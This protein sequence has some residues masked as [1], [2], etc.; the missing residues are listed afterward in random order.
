MRKS[1]SGS[2][3]VLK[4]V[5]YHEAGHAVAYWYFFNGPRFK[6]VTIK[7]EE[8]AWGRIVGRLSR[9]NPDEDSGVRF[10]VRS[11]DRIIRSLAGP[12]AERRLRGK[13]DHRGASG[14]WSAVADLV[15]N[16]TGSERQATALMRYFDIVTEEFIEFRWHDIEVVAAALLERTTLTYK[17]VQQILF[18]EF[19]HIC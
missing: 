19:S 12:A 5:A 6:Y 9:W 17:E 4:Y 16:M 8:A 2:D 14:D 10:F 18:P 3:D 15:F 7:P 1:K 11:R 13:Y